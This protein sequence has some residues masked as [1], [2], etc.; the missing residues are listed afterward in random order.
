MG[1]EALIEML[2]RVELDSLSHELRHTEKNET[3]Q[4][5]KTESLKRL[6]VVEA[7][8]EAQVHTENRP[9]WMILKVLLY[10]SFRSEVANL[11]PSKGTN[12]L[13]SGGITGRTF[14]IIHSGLFSGCT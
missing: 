5:R 1:A 10:K 3:S 8:K 6:Q 4:Q 7:F 9:E 13:N 12:G 14:N 2:K 11:P